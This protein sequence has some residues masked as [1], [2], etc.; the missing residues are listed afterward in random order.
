MKEILEAFA[1]ALNW[2]F[3]YG[4]ADFQ[5]LADIAEQKDVSHLFLDPVKLIKN[6]NDSGVVESM[7]YSGSFM[8]LYSSD[9]DEKSYNIRYE[10]YIKPIIDGQVVLIE[11]ELICNKEATLVQ[12]E[13][14]ELINIF[15]Y[16]FDG[17]LVAYK[18]VI[19]E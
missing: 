7:G 18:V 5:N 10:N 19:D 17:V 14:T 4:R 1:T 13:I 16:N 2:F 6:R 15:D 8:L 3:E 9:I 11:D 12:W